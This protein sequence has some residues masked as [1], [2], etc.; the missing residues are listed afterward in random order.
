MTL[1]AYWTAQQREQFRAHPELIATQ[2]GPPSVPRLGPL[3]PHPRG[4]ALTND[5]RRFVTIPAGRRSGKTERAK[6]HLTKEAISVQGYDDAAYFAGAPTRDQ[7]KRIFWNDFKAMFPRELVAKTSESDLIIKLI[8][9][10]EVHVVGL[11]KPARIEGKSWNGGLLDEVGNMKP[12]VWG[13]NI[14]P[15]LS[16]RMGWC[17]LL[18]VPEGRNHYYELDQYARTSGDPEWGSHNWP[19]S[20]VLPASEVAA[21]RRQ[22]DPLVFQQEY[23]ASFINFVGRAYYTFSEA[24]NVRDLFYDDL[25]DLAFCFDFNVDPG[26][27]VV[28]QE[29]ELPGQYE[30]DST[31]LLNLARPVTGTGVI[32]EVYIPR[33]SNTPAVCR[34]LIADW[35]EHRG[36]V[37]CY[38]DAT[39]G[40]RGS[41][42]V[43]GSDW[44]LIKRELG[45]H[46]GDRL[47]FRVPAA[48][49]AER[50]RINALNTRC[51]TGEG[52][53]RLMVDKG[54]APHVVKDLEGVRLLEG[55]SGEIDKKHDPKLTHLSDSLGYYVVREFPIHD[56]SVGPTLIRM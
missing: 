26:V 32:G 10:T 56:N 15:A 2:G 30:L 31:G 36:N 7:A 50:A 52:V 41:A 27:A 17:W 6:R 1:P 16:D 9:N 45:A 25:A 28:C 43:Q 37:F 4:E 47:Y 22:L 53:R 18:G 38:G 19:S 11:D 21:A 5:Q 13:E 29:Q 23:E 46:F 8:T 33:N 3:R 14:R 12:G 44:E 49:P 34:K 24:D 40:A 54:A 48:N 35:G 55:G 51:R 42:K 39:G 20:D